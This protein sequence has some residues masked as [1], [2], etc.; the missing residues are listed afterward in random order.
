MFTGLIAQSVAEGRLMGFVEGLHVTLDGTGP[1]IVLCSGL[2]GNWFEWDALTECL[3][4][5]RTIIR[6][7][8]P[9]YGHSPAT[10]P[11]PSIHAEADRLRQIL[12]R[13]RTE[14]AVIVGHS[15]GGLY[16][17]GFARIHPQRTAGLVLLDASIPA[18][19]PRLLSA[20]RRD[21]IARQ[22]SRLLTATGLPRRLAPRVY[23]S[24]VTVDDDQNQAWQSIMTEVTR[25]PTYLEALLR[26]FAAF[27]ALSAELLDIREKTTL[28]RPRLV[29]A[30][31]DGRWMPQSWRWVRSQ[32]RSAQT[33]AADFVLLRPAAHHMMIDRPQEVATLIRSVQAR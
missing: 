32:Q 4:S 33:L 19:R 18:R 24:A 25:S 3:S 2:G 7:D 27:P 9:G 17:E 15:L 23:R 5:D 20:D 28:R 10:E 21:H 8:R 31:D 30:A 26:E 6:I 1:P 12:H 11:A 14:P 22:I 13:T 29:V 16:A